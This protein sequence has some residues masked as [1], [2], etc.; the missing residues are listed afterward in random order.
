MKPTATIS[1]QGDLRT[2][3]THNKSG[4]SIITDAP[5]DNEGK[6]EAFSPT[7]LVATALVSCMITVVGIKARDRQWDMGSLTG[8]VE[9]V[10]DSHPRR[11]ARLEVKMMFEGHSLSTKERHVLEQVAMTCPVAKSLSSDLQM[12]V[13]FSYD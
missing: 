11:I 5:T 3:A 7:D 1:Y 6:G 4:E 10:M 8:T 2:K 9:K 13:Q 12:E